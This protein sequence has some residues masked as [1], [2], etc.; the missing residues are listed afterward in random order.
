MPVVVRKLKDPDVN[1]C[2]AES[3]A[4]NRC[5]NDHNYDRDRCVVHFLKYKNCKRFWNSVMVQRR[6]S[7]VHPPLPPA[8]EREEMLRAMGERPY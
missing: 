3:D 8:A 1:P 2:L 5:M 7:G 6:R 4:S